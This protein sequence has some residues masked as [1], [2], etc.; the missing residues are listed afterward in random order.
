[1]KKYVLLALLA[2]M[3][4]AGCSCNKTTEPTKVY[5]P[6]VE[7]NYYVLR[8]AK[9][10]T[11]AVIEEIK[12][13]QNLVEIKD[14]ETNLVPIEEV[15][16][17]PLV[18]IAYITKPE[19]TESEIYNYIF[20]ECAEREIDPYMVMAMIQHESHWDADIIGDNGNAFGLMQIQPRW[21][22]E[23]IENLGVTDLLD[24]IQNISV[25]IDYIDELIDMG[26]GLDW[27]LMCYNGGPALANRRKNIN[28]AIT[29]QN[30]AAE[31]AEK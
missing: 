2:S 27:A 7:I 23:R 24:P 19:P 10:E 9:A 14:V 4:V 26:K 28:Y 20:D 15:K 12:P 6:Q 22:A 31:L 5:A 3:A 30:T 18:S 8:E 16:P 25:G 17:E 13:E 1:M 11:L 29:I 21:H